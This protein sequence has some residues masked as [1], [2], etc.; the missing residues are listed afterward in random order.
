LK[1]SYGVQSGAAHARC[2]LG[3]SRAT[4]QC[5]PTLLNKLQAELIHTDRDAL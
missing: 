4:P 2:M 3:Q 1:V 5:T